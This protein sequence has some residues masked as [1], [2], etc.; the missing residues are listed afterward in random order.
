[1]FLTVKSESLR[2]LSDYLNTPIVNYISFDLEE[3]GGIISFCI[4]LSYDLEINQVQQIKFLLT[5]KTHKLQDRRNF[6]RLDIRKQAFNRNSVRKY[7]FNIYK[8]LRTT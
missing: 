4:K 1:M 2:D 3:Q 6:S 5:K 7:A 8:S